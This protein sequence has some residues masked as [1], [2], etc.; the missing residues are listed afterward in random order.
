MREL[1]PSGSVNF[2]YDIVQISTAEG[3]RPFWTV[4]NLPGSWGAARAGG[5][6]D[7]V[8]QDRKLP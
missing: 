2:T 8:I 6:G 4:D 3:Q 7:L 1:A 5:L